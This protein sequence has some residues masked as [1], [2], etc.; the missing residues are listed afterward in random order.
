MAKTNKKLPIYNLSTATLY[1]KRREEM[2]DLRKQGITLAE[3]GKRY[4]LTRE[5]VRQI[6]SDDVP[7]EVAI[8]ARKQQS[9]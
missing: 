1:I 4:G 9:L 8:K 5:R 3:I 2:L 6:T 7:A